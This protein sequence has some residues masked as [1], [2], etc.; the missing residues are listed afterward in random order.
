[1]SVEAQCVMTA[2]ESQVEALIFL[3]QFTSKKGE[4]TAFTPYRI[5]SP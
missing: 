5:R 4:E 1:M 3:N 2:S